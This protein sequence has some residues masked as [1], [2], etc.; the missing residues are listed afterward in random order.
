MLVK[1]FFILLK[2]INS[3]SFTICFNHTG[4]SSGNTLFSRNISHCTQCHSYVV[5][6][7][8]LIWCYMVSPL[9]IFCV[10]AAVCKVWYMFTSVILSLFFWLCH[11]PLSRYCAF[12]LTYTIGCTAS[13]SRV[14]FCVPCTDL[15]WLF[16]L[17]YLSR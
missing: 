4:P 6:R 14:R 7:C 15:V 17:K 16:S 8:V 3:I 9:P 1:M 10:A 2:Y 13:W 11:L 5:C 12:E